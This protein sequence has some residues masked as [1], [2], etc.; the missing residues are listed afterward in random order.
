MQR[1]CLLLVEDERSHSELL[2]MF[3]EAAGY[4]T[5]TDWDGLLAPS[6]ARALQPDVIT[7]DLELPA[8]DGRRV[9]ASLKA[10]PSTAAIPVVII[11]AHADLLRRPERDAAFAV[12]PKPFDLDHL[13]ATVQRAAAGS[14][15]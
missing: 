12:L 6:L 14:L 4:R 2:Q 7:L 1:G 11:S 5:V 10:D 15:V 13:V 3:L 9:L 8:V